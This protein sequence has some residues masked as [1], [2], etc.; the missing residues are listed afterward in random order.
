MNSDL[1]RFQQIIDLSQ[2]WVLQSFYHYRPRHMPLLL[3]MRIFEMSHCYDVAR[4]FLWQFRKQDSKTDILGCSLFHSL[5]CYGQW[6]GLEIS[7]W[8][9]SYC[10]DFYMYKQTEQKI[11]HPCSI[12]VLGVEWHWH[13][14]RGQLTIQ[15]RATLVS[16]TVHNSDTLRSS[17]KGAASAG[18][19]SAPLC[20]NMRI[21][22]PGVALKSP[23]S[24]FPAY[25]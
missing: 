3:K 8:V 5:V 9:V 21:S 12:V 14:Q 24:G 18:V 2:I 10:V 19:I 11:A 16:V 7:V 25:V 22:M 20:R 1:R 17:F 13:S 23:V 4:I 6:F 15:Q